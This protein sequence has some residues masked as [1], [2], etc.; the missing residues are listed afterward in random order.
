MEDDEFCQMFLYT[1]IN[2]IC[3]LLSTI[4]LT[5]LYNVNS[6]IK[7]LRIESESKFESYRNSY[8]AISVLFTF[9]FFG[10]VGFMLIL[11]LLIKRSKVNKADNER[12]TLLKIQE[13][14]TSLEK[15]EET[16]D[17]IPNYLPVKT[18]SF[19]L[20]S[21]SFIKAGTLNKVMFFLFIYCQFVFLIQVIVLTVYHSKSTDL[22]K[23]LEKEFDEK[24][25]GKYLT[26]VYRDLIAAGYIFLFFFILFDLYTLI[27][28]TDCGKRD[29]KNGNKINTTKYHKKVN[30]EDFSKHRYCGFFNNCLA[31]CCDKMGNVF[32]ACERDD[33]ESKQKFEEDLKKLKDELEVL[34]T[35]SKNL[36]E[37]N[38]KI[39]RKQNVKKEDFEKLH[40]PKLD[41]DNTTTTA[42]KFYK[43]TKK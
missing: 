40:L 38:G 32:K 2:L 16:K 20:D 5:C 39:K 30:A 15:D 13:I 3:F 34:K 35:Y 28:M 8:T 29:K 36:E 37:L 23:E 1:L 14:K 18:D 4:N 22:Q 25:F 33:E 6:Q 10:F 43:P 17:I 21:V 42:S 24:K 31:K 41:A 11:M 9:D 12:L 27:L 26:S 19:A 7:I